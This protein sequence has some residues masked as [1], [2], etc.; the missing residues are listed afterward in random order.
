MA[1]LSQRLRLP[2]LLTKPWL[3][4]RGQRILAL[5]VLRGTRCLAKRERRLSLAAAEARG[6]DAVLAEFPLWNIGWFLEP[7]IAAHFFF[8]TIQRPINLLTWMYSFV[9]KKAGAP[10][11]GSSTWISNKSKHYVLHGNQMR[12]SDIVLP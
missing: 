2:R 11:L 8:A 1:A 9:S 6:R 5:T 12:F 7:P 4:A 10:G 3:G